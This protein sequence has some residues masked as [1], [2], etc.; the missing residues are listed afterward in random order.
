MLPSR[1]IQELIS[2]F[3]FAASL[4]S[5]V[6]VAL[7]GTLFLLRHGNE[8]LRREVFI[9]SQYEITFEHF[10]YF[11][12]LLTPLGLIELGLLCLVLAQ[13]VR[14]ALI[15]WAYI[16]AKDYYFTAFSSF[17]FFALIYSSFLRN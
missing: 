14:V 12:Q 11:K 7:G 9:T 17:I 5:T 13:L 2:T 10:L 16:A 15:T 8:S 3:L 6:L 1:P 4:V